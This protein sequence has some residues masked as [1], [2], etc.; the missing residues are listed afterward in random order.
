MPE[1]AL[2]NEENENQAKA[3]APAKAPAKS[4]FMKYL[5]IGVAIIIVI[6]AVALG[7]AFIMGG[8]SRSAADETAETATTESGPGKIDIR[9]KPGD[10]QQKDQ[11]P[12]GELATTGDEELD[13]A[14]VD[15]TAIEKIMENLAFL[16]YEP[17]EDEIAQEEGRMTK[18]DSLEQVNWLDQ[19]KQTLTRRTKELDAREK[20]L[21]KREVKIEQALVKLEQV[22]STR[23]ASL[24]KL[25]DG[26]D[27]RSVAK[28]LA[29]LDD[30]TVVSILP[31]MKVKNAS[32]VLQLMPP[33]R[34]AKLSK[35]MIT[36]AEK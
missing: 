21:A 12:T 28:L 22:E 31:R 8:D 33:Q 17:S 6:C 20:D 35:Q 9:P 16:D 2:Q 13:P 4:D 5:L 25:Y 15:A 19:E 7:T 26:M 24:A 36:I 18:D 11:Q 1:E 34:A 32:A 27:A 14:E 29:N 10:P 30:A 23:I 3:E